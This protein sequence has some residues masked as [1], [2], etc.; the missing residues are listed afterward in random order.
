MF[1]DI[2]LE[3]MKLS[4]ALFNILEYHNRPDVI[5]ANVF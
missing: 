1:W 2:I 4:L 5:F 3:A